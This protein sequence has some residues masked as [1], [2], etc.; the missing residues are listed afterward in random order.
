MAVCAPTHERMDLNPVLGRRRFDGNKARDLFQRS[1][2][3]GMD[4]FVAERSSFSQEDYFGLRP[5][6]YVA[7]SFSYCPIPKVLTIVDCMPISKYFI[8]ERL[9]KVSNKW[10]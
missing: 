7:N 6:C 8:D 1:V 9:C 5:V 10:Q 3:F 4:Y 2:V